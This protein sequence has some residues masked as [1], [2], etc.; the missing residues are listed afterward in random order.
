[1]NGSLI[2]YVP[3]ARDGILHLPYANIRGLTIGIDNPFIRTIPDGNV[4]H[5]KPT[6]RAVRS[7]PC[8]SPVHLF[9]HKE[10]FM[11]LYIGHVNMAIN[12]V[13]YGDKPLMGTFQSVNI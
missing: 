3:L 6:N 12:T 7:K 8:Q 1:M 13:Q 5:G 2:G 10:D 4:P 11:A 9:I